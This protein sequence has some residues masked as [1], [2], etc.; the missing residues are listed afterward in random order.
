MSVTCMVCKHTYAIDKA[1]KHCRHCG[2]R[3]WPELVKPIAA[4]CDRLGVKLPLG[5]L[6]K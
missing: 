2:T 6:L 1:P 4:H 5:V 3:L